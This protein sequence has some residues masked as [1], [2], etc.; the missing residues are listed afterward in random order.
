MDVGSTLSD[1]PEPVNTFV[2]EKGKTNANMAALDELREYFAKL[3][4]CDD[5]FS[6]EDASTALQEITEGL[7]LH[8]VAR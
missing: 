2:V 8:E 5:G 4:D 1:I 3:V 6:A 7:E